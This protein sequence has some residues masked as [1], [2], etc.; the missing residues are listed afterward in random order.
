MMT[1]LAPR[2]WCGR[3]GDWRDFFP[4]WGSVGFYPSCAHCPYVACW[5]GGR[6]REYW[7]ATGGGYFW[8]IR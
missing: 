2:L 5:E 3:F 8:R 1:W 4:R 6:C 7:V